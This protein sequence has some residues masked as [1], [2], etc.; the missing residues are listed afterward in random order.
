MAQKDARPQRTALS[1][2]NDAEAE[3][4]W[5]AWTWTSETMAKPV[6][7]GAKVAPDGLR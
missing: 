5:T 2:R 7:A 6:E 4:F 3:L 1:E